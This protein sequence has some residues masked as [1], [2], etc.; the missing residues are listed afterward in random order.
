MKVVVTG[1]TGNIG[2]RLVSALQG[3][4]DVDE[5]VGIARRRPADDSSGV[6]WVAADL[7]VDDLSTTLRGADAV[8]HLA[9]LIQPSHDEDVLWRTNVIGTERLLDACDAAGV[10]TVVHASSLAAYRPGP[11]E[12]V[13]ESWP[14]DGIATSAYARAKAYTER[15]LELYEV[16]HPAVRVVRLRPALVLQ[17]QVATEIR[18]LF[19]GPFLPNRLLRAALPVVPD[20]PG[21]RFQVVHSS[22]CAEAFRLAVTLEHARG[23]YNVATEPVVDPAML[24]RVLG[25]RPV[26]VPGGLLRGAADLTWRL[27]LQPTDPGWVDIVLRTPLLD[28]TRIRTE[29]GWEP[30]RGAEETLDEIVTGIVQ[31]A[32]GHTPPLSREAGG[33]LRSRELAT[34]VG[35][36]SGAVPDDPT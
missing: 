11:K 3:D 4:P 16:E 7:S 20:H 12:R 28:T 34:G 14:T 23:A 5:I 6:T 10:G 2:S 36:T 21:L 26:S 18:R 31:G 25:A 8:V 15:L 1:A 19:L 13:D 27:R 33:P 9:W 35:G 22:D 24:G 30:A 17:R 32:T 29:L